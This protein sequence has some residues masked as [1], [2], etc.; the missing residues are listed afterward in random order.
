MTEELYTEHLK[1]KN[2]GFDLKSKD[3]LSANN[4]DTV[5]Y[6]ADTEVL[7]IAPFNDANCMFFRTKLNLH[8][9]TF[10]NL[11]DKEVMNYLWTEVNG[12]LEAPTFVS[13]YISE[14]KYVKKKYP[15][16]STIILWTDGC[17][18]QNRNA[19]LSSALANFAKKNKVNI[20]SNIKSF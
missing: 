10:F 4:T 3:K 12:D 6:T 1:R 17:C 13:C 14:L 7:L 5:V 8:N 16:V 15:N 18:Y 2:E 9:F 11:H 20:F 19:V